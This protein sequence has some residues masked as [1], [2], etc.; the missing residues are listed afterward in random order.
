MTRL[1]WLN[2]FGKE[3]FPILSGGAPDRTAKEAVLVAAGKT[4][5]A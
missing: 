2:C 1:C 3:V 4:L 5:G